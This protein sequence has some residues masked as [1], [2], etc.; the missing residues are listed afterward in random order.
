MTE[1]EIN[2]FL[3]EV[4]KQQQDLTYLQR[5]LIESIEALRSELAKAMAPMTE[6]KF[7]NQ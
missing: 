3:D 5:E 1:Q 4:A 6:P 2:Y 7:K